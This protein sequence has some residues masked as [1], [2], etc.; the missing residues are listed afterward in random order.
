MADAMQG[1]TCP[2]CQADMRS[3]E[4]NGVVVDQCTGCRGIFFDKGEFER[5]VDAE[6]THYSGSDPPQRDDDKREHEGKGQGKRKRRSFLEGLF[7]G[8]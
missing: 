8:E 7:E 2:K 1:L 3:Y 5:L 4:R 6:S